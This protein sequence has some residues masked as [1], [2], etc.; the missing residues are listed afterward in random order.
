[1]GKQVPLSNLPACANTCGQSGGGKSK[2]TKMV[3]STIGSENLSGSSLAHKATRG[4]CATTTKNYRSAKQPNDILTQQRS[5]S[6]LR[7]N[8]S[9]IKT[10]CQHDTAPLKASARHETNRKNK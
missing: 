7:I 9:D 2:A 10:P 1:M 4:K 6:Y 8:L 3:G 5:P